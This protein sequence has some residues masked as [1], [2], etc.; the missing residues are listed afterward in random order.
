MSD[1]L[2]SKCKS[3][4]LCPGYDWFSMAEIRFCPDQTRWMLENLT[5][6]ERGKWP[7]EYST[8]TPAEP[9]NR[10]P[11]GNAPFE[12]PVEYSAEIKWRVGQCG[13]DGTLT[14][15]ILADGWDEQTLAEVMG[16]TIK[17]LDRRVNRVVGYCSGWKRRIQSY[18]DYCKRGREGKKCPIL[19][20]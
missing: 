9:S 11:P 16:T 5:T 2:C 14:Y 18:D 17:K 8:K 13:I 10:Q 3:W 19:P 15:Q 6:L 20:S 12:R 4:K 7:A 1:K